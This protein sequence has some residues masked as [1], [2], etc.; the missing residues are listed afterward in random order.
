MTLWLEYTS[1]Y[2]WI[3]TH[4][5]PPPVG[6]QLP[7]LD[8]HHHPSTTTTKTTKNPPQPAEDIKTTTNPPPTPPEVKP[9]SYVSGICDV[10]GA[11]AKLRWRYAKKKTTD[12][13]LTREFFHVCDTRL[14]RRKLVQQTLFSSLRKTPGVMKGNT[15]G[16]TTKHGGHFT[17]T[18]GQS[19]AQTSGLELPEP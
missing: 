11:G 12:K 13:G 10:H 16:D 6:C 19:D 3:P 17:H 18:E 4:Q 2:T 5:P 7:R 8:N 14:G 1:L 9:C 15:Q